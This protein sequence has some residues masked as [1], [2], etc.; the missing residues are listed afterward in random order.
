MRI[1]RKKRPEKQQINFRMNER[2]RALRLR[3]VDDE[4][5]F[6]GIMSREEA[7]SLARE[8]EMDLV[9]IVPKGEVPVAKITDYGRF[10]YQ[11]EKEL[12]KQKSAQKK[13]EV[14]GI[15]LSLRIGQHDSDLRIRRAVEFLKDN[16]KVRVELV[17]KGREKGKG[18]L[19]REVLDNFIKTL[20][21]QHPIKID[22]PAT[23]QGAKI[24]VVV[25][26]SQ[27]V[28]NKEEME[29]GQEDK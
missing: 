27:K 16:D 23:R 11:K 2:I 22:Q 6:L 25:A 7:L 20:D 28:E 14:K 10:K 9:E 24:F 15:R 18:D 21:S 17:L 3:V 26:P 4:G 13:T 5:D 8:K 19:G 29:S 12:K 1:S